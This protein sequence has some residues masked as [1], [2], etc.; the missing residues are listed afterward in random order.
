M[1]GPA[2]QPRRDWI[3]NRHPTVAK[4]GAEGFDSVRRAGKFLWTACC[5]RWRHSYRGRQST[6][7]PWP[8]LMYQRDWMP[9]TKF[10]PRR[11]RTAASPCTHTRSRT[12]AAHGRLMPH[13]AKRSDA[14]PSGPR[15]RRA[16]QKLM[17]WQPRFLPCWLYAGW[18]MSR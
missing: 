14:S 5:G 4:K 13:R 17:R 3:P 7:N 9:A 11:A 15:W 8:S 10:T 1:G 18:L 16:C 12:G 2:Q 6:T